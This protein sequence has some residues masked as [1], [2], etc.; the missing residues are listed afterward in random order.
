MTGRKRGWS[1]WKRGYISYLRIFTP[2]FVLRNTTNLMKKKKN[3]LV[4]TSLAPDFSIHTLK[5]NFCKTVNNIGPATCAFKI[6]NKV[7]PEWSHIP[8]RNIPYDFSWISA[9]SWFSS[10][11]YEKLKIKSSKE[12]EIRSIILEFKMDFYSTD[13]LYKFFI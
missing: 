11:H 4:A 7:I 1:T 10:V 9:L 3:Q 12:K 13:F 8:I 2:S 6:R 5:T